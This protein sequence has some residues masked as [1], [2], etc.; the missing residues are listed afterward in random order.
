M[1]DSSQSQHPTKT[2]ESGYWKVVDCRAF[3]R[4]VRDNAGDNGFA[5]VTGFAGGPLVIY[6]DGKH[7]RHRSANED[8]PFLIREEVA[9]M[10]GCHPDKLSWRPIREKMEAQG[11]I[12]RR[13]G[14]S[15]KMWRREDVIAY[16]ERQGL[17]GKRGPGRPRKSV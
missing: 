15:R 3:W 8:S 4:S 9:E 12:G 14:G 11:L 1:S 7:C 17:T 2:T 13:V 10:L 5:V 16:A 6:G